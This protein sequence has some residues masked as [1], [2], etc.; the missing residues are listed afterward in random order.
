M[1]PDSFEASGCRR[2]AGLAPARVLMR[3]LLLLSSQ[4]DVYNDS[5]KKVGILAADKNLFLL[6]VNFNS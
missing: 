6:L 5:K 4:T 1:R 2:T 3:N